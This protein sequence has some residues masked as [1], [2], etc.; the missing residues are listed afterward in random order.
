MKLQTA[1]DV[2]F[3]HT[4]LPPAPLRNT[5]KPKCRAFVFSLGIGF[6]YLAGVP[7]RPPLARIT[8]VSLHFNPEGGGWGRGLW[9]T[10]S[11]HTI[12]GQQPIKARYLFITEPGKPGEH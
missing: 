5:K 3:Q 6:V 9:G 7:N 1:L 2:V 11:P 8:F 4:M 10:L 12:K